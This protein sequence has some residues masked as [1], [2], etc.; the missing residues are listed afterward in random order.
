MLLRIPKLAKCK[1]AS[2][3][4]RDCELTQGESIL[5]V[6][7]CLL[8]DGELTKHILQRSG[9]LFYRRSRR[10]ANPNSAPRQYQRRR[11][12]E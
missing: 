12:K 8:I 5:Q 7:V 4:H 2:Y 10:R 3:P 9:F 11:K 1:C 6:T